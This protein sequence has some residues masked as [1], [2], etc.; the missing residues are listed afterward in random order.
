MQQQRL[1]QH[2]PL[3]GVGV[4]LPHPALQEVDPSQGAEGAQQLAEDPPGRGL[5][6]EGGGGGGGGGGSFMK[7]R[8]LR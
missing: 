1:G 8:E 7:S 3:P 6:G 2:Q 5:G 4:G